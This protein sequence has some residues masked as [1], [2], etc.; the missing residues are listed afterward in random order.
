[1]LIK[2][3]IVDDEAPA[4]DELTRLIAQ[5]PGTKLVAALGVPAQVVPRLREAEC[6]LVL[7]D[8]RMPGQSGLA[9]AGEILGLDRPPHIAFV[10]AFDDH[11]LE[12]FD[13]E[14]L[15]YI[16]TPASLERLRR[17]VERV[18]ERTVRPPTAD[19][20]ARLGAPSEPPILVGSMPGSPRRYL[21]RP[22]DL[23]YV[24]AEDELVWLVCE[25]TKSLSSKTLTELEVL[26]R[27]HRFVRTQRS[28]LVNLDHVVEIITTPSG[29]CTLRLDC[30]GH[31]VLV[32]RRHW[33]DL[34]RRIEG[35]GLES[36]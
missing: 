19:V 15:D 6:D 29:A 20:L 16:L 28:F 2:V 36:A 35:S 1:M 32:S 5:I 12:A 13:R 14:A 9:L 4:R 21:V 30:E 31:E 11:A 23:L 22:A 34:K 25:R 8:I 27:P 24:K 26:L 3:M 7:L 18:W 10:T 17:L 33:P